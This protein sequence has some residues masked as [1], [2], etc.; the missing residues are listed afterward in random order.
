MR[1]H[2]VGSSAAVPRPNRANSCY[3]IESE[4]T[5]I[6]LDCGSGAFARLRVA[7][8]LTTLAAVF[9]SHMHADHFID[10]IAMRYAMKYEFRRAS[11]LPVYLH[12]GAHSVLDRVVAPFK[13]GEDF[14]RDVFEFRTYDEA[15]AIA[16][17]SFTL[18][19]AIS[20]HYISAYAMRVESGAT[21]LT[22][23]ADTAPDDAVSEL[24]HGS[25]VFLCE[26]ALGAD[27][28]DREPRGHSNAREAGMMAAAAGVRHLVITHY[29]AQAD[30]LEMNA[31]ASSAFGGSITIADDGLTLP[32]S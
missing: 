20:K 9:V 11:P 31:A 5:A 15:S 6:V 32:V 23:S 10:L 19:F 30:P 4:G 29:D 8:D 27:G 3:L 28:E 25:D 2:V 18:R 12:R 13:D 16:V 24:A 7:T 14:F 1:L 26:S 17:E 21:A 22:Y